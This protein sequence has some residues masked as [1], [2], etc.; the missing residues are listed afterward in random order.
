MA[1][2]NLQELL[3]QG[4]E[5]AREGRKAEAREY[6]E[7]VVE[8]DEKNERGWFWLASVVESEDEKRICLKNV[9]QI[10]PNNERA[11]KALAQLEAKQERGRAD[12]EV[13]PGITR[14]QMTLVVGAGGTVIVLILAAFFVIGG[15][16]S[17]QTAEQ[18]RAVEQLLQTQ[19]QETAAQEMIA[20]QATGTAQALI[21]P[22]IVP[23]NTPRFEA[24][25]TFT[26]EATEAAAGPT[27][28]PPPPGSLSGSLVAWSGRD[29]SQ[30][31]FLP[32][33]LFP[34][35]GGPSTV[36]TD[37]VGAHPDVSPDGQR[38]LYTR[39]FPAT[40]DFGISQ[41]NL[42]SGD[43][44]PL[45]QGTPILK[46]QMPYY[47]STANLVTFVALPTDS[48]SIDFSNSSVQAFQVFMLNLDSN[49]FD[50]LTND[51]AVY[52]YPAFS[53]DCTRI[54]LVR[55]DARGTTP[56]A[57]IVILD[58]VARTQTPITN[59]LGNFIESAPRWSADGTQL[60]YAA[61]QSTTPGNHDIIVRASDGSGSP[62]VP[63][64]DMA[65]DINPVFS[66]DGAYIA[67]SSNRA[68][69]YDLFVYEQATQ[70]IYQLTSGGD[71]DYVWSWK[72]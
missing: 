49:Q 51:Q 37:V 4:V 30:K 34:L 21:T 55:D 65:D 25:W 62:L 11:Q 71:D 3:K 6:F 27:P 38:V 35:N 12:E 66:P 7:K 64:R 60:T 5:A 31:G 54:A 18:T 13:M 63:V 16:S 33:R 40:F 44:R 58:V 15:A 45:M 32:I 53:P 29:I 50:R 20:A 72:P 47:C 56:G 36:I 2:E 1:D 17:R 48:R 46:P 10:N 43:N 14:R 8:L 39:Y 70:A 9:V 69:T 67:F 26:P 24:T 22:T 57:D 61:Y 41:I 68:G 42:T 59:D 52:T 28:L 19:A 23:S